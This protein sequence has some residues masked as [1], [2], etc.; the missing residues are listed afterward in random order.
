MLFI[1]ANLYS[2]DRAG[3]I[4]KGFLLTEGSKIAALGPMES[5][6]AVT[7]E[8]I[9]LCGKLLLPGFIDA[10]SHLGMI[11]DSVGNEGDDINEMSDP[12]TPQLRAID[13]IN[14]FDRGFTEALSGGVTAV[15][16]GPGSA[17]PIGG[18]TALIKTWGKSADRMLIPEVRGMKFAM[19][20][21][22]KAVYGEKHQSPTTRMGEAA[23]IR[24]QLYK[25]KRYL[26][27]LEAAQKDSE[28]DPPEY[29]IKCEALLPLLKREAKAHF[30]AHR[31][32]DISTAM[33][34]SAEFE[35]DYLLVHCTEGHLIADLLAEAEAKVINGPIM[36]FRCKPELRN[37]EAAESS[38]KLIDAG[39]QVAICTDHPEVTSEYLAFSAA[40]ATKGLDFEQ[41]LAT[42]TSHAAAIL[43]TDRI[44]SLAPGKDADF[45]VFGGSPFEIHARPEMVWIDGERR[46]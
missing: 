17:N 23:I 2:M 1:N 20:E 45:S 12:C 41:T 25:T 21:N 33:R 15:M 19:G 39:L 24:E 11:E 34:I 42:I 22:P 26:A 31:A 13:G 40:V 43:G 8:T 16:T 36:G 29:D 18:Q 28:L 30:H 7:G 44:G 9:D 10:H 32:S 6:P 37:F 14:P 3:H 38:R 46:V 5:C 4:E 27:D 35:L